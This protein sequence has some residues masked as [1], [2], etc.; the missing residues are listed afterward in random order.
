MSGK[1]RE[2]EIELRKLEGERRDAEY[3]LRTIEASPRNR[4][5]LAG[6]FSRPPRRDGDTRIRG[7]EEEESSEPS[8]KPRLNVELRK[9]ENEED[10]V[11]S[12]EKE[13]VTKEDNTEENKDKSEAPKESTGEEEKPKRQM[14]TS[15]GGEVRKRD[16][17]LFGSLLGHLNKAQTRLSK[18]QETDAIKKQ[19]EVDEKVKDKIS[20]RTVNIRERESLQLIKQRDEERAAR[21][22]IVRKEEATRRELDEIVVLEHNEQLGNYILTSTTPHVYFLPASHTDKTKS[23]LTK[24]K[25][26]NE[27]RIEENPVVLEKDLDQGFI[28]A[29][30]LE[31]QRDTK[32]DDETKVEDGS[33]KMNED[34]EKTEVAKAEDSKKSHEGKKSDSESSDASGSDE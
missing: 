25:K 3:R 7:R 8:K 34:E 12:T 16:K 24:S 2:L 1:R 28:D 26:A 31:R 10:E 27:K 19:K 14:R 33:S 22:A 15:K 18:D 11:E 6:D 23:L 9:K 30:F 29:I 20:Q 32:Q 17:R 4:R 5:L 13:P 21:E